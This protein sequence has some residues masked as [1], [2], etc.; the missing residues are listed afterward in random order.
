MNKN[1]LDEFIKNPK[2]SLWKLS[3]PMMLG[4]SVQAIYML[5]DTMFVGKFVP[6]SKAALDAMGVI[7]PLM[8]IIMGLTFGLGSGV[9][10][11]IAQYIGAKNKKAADSVAS[12][13]DIIGLVLP[14]LIITIVLILGDGIIGVQLR[15]IEGQT[16][17]YAKQYFNIMAFGSV[18]MILAI[19]LQFTGK[20]ELD[21]SELTDSNKNSEDSDKLL[22]KVFPIRFMKNLIKYCNYYLD[23]KFFTKL[24]T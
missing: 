22:D 14:I 11:L 21:P 5:I 9:A 1:R 7:F 15:D 23:D 18:F 2:I 17:I 12:H 4:M 24:S 19:S 16:L 20:E 3:I 6:D 10:T 13:T 8:F